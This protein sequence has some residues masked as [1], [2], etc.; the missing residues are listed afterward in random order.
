M[1]I[2]YD[3]LE[4]LSYPI[5]AQIHVVQYCSFMFLYITI[6]RIF[7]IFR[8]LIPGGLHMKGAGILVVS[9]SVAREE[10]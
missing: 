2:K 7:S 8:D 6:V 9:L 1:A 10:I 3:L 5:F 4:N